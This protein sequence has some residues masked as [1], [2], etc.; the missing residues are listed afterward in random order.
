MKYVIL[1]AA[2]VIQVCL[3]GIYAWSKLDTTLQ[4]TVGMSTTETSIIFGGLFPAFTVSMVLAGRLLDRLGPRVIAGIGGLLFGAGYLIASFSDGNCPLM[5]LGISVCA[6][7]G[8]GFGYVC[9]LTT[10]IKWF[11][12]KRGLVTGISMAGFGGG[13]VL[14]TA[15]SHYLLSHGVHVLMVFRWVGIAYMLAI[16]VA[17]MLLRFPTSEIGARVSPTP[18]IRTLLRDP[19]LL[20]LVLGM[21]CGTFAGM[22]VVSKINDMGLWAGLPKAWAATAVAAFSIGNAAGRITWGWVSDWTDERMI[23]VKLITLGVPVGLLAVVNSSMLFVVVSFAVGFGFGACFVLYAAQVA[24]RYGAARV[25]GIYPLVFLAYGV[26]GLVGPASGGWLYDVT[27]SWLPAIAVSCGIVA[28]GIIASL[29]L[30][31]KAK[32]CR[33]FY[34]TEA[35]T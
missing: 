16:L 23:P 29:M 19:F 18:A 27:A 17:A 10:C 34:V 1:A 12:N 2:L 8:T 9:P 3:G 5:L 7:I 24:A 28:T 6:G 35:P 15:L 13:A 25:G 4:N 31:K 20:S 22:F 14:L 26:A 33:L 32:Q 21:F 30:L 11:P